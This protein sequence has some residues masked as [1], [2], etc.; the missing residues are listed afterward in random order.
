M[1]LPSTLTLAARPAPAGFF[2]ISFRI[3]VLFAA[4]PT[5]FMSACTL[6]CGCL[7]HSHFAQSKSNTLSDLLSAF[8]TTEQKHSLEPTPCRHNQR[9]AVCTCLEPCA[10]NRVQAREWISEKLRQQAVRSFALCQT[11]ALDN[12][13]LRHLIASVCTWLCHRTL[14]TSMRTMLMMRQVTNCESASGTN[15]TSRWPT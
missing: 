6:L 5:G 2:F 11:F 14:L 13:F 10:I 7:H 12:M 8:H 4:F 1:P 15:E 9:E 3:S